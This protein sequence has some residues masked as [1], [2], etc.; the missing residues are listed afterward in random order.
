MPTAIFVALVAGL[1]RG[2]DDALPWLAAGIVSIL[3][4]AFMPGPWY[5]PLGAMAGL[6]AG[7]ASQRWLH[8]S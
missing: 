3:V 5:V 6:I 8:A 7:L 1:W 4:H 2:K